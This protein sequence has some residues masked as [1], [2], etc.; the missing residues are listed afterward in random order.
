M[1]KGDAIEASFNRLVASGVDGFTID[2]DGAEYKDKEGYA[3]AYTTHDSLKDALEHIKPN[4]YVG[5]WRDPETGREYV[6]V[7]DIISSALEAV[8]TGL[9]RKQRAIYSFAV[10]DI[11]DLSGFYNE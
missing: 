8:F 2:Q 5:F 9:A 1:K 11:V 10:D 3:V 4:Q 6:E 7:V